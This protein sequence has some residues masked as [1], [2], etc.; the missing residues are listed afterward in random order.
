MTSKT[1]YAITA[2]FISTILLSFTGCGGGK[3]DDNRSPTVDVTGSWTG[4][5]SGAVESGDFNFV[6]TQTGNDVEGI[7]TRLGR[8]TGNVQANNFYIKGTDVFGI[9]N[10]NTIS[11]TYTDTIGEV[12]SFF[13]ERTDDSF[14]TA[15]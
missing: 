6:M 5:W 14:I 10:G 8:F 9:V 4:T 13:C 1:A 15:Q 7:N 11:G 2:I 12:I 3:E